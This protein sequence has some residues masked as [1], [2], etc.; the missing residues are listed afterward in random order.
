MPGYVLTANTDTSGVIKVKDISTNESPVQA[1][2]S[3]AND[4]RLKV[5]E[6][7]SLT[8]LLSDRLFGI[9]GGV[10]QLD[11]DGNLSMPGYVLTANT[12]TSGVIKVKD[13]STNESPV[14][15]VR[16]GAND[17]R[18]KVLEQG[19]LTSLLSDR[20]FGISGGVP[21]LNT[22]G[23]I[24]TAHLPFLIEEY[25]NHTGT[26][27][28][29]TIKNT[30]GTG[31]VTEDS[32]THSIKIS[33]GDTYDSRGGIELGDSVPVDKNVTVLQCKVRDYTTIPNSLSKVNIG[34]SS[35][36]NH[37]PFTVNIG[38]IYTNDGTWEVF[39]RDKVA[40]ETTVQV[41]ISKGDILTVEIYNNSAVLFINGGQVY[42]APSN[43]LEGNMTPC[44]MAYNHFSPPAAAVNMYVDAISLKR[45][46]GR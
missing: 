35:S 4:W 6:Q 2:R 36:P 23:R 21:Q 18:L 16:S 24:E 29:F 19:S 28:N 30:Q 31:S 7:G 42:A 9:S 45:Y 20:L 10:P 1:V 33:S 34:F 8:S 14:Q 43:I 3:G 5:L 25:T 37:D 13:I 15:A 44:I 41:S 26:L 32:L 39:L 27:D 22:L 11:P 12:D 40:N 38:F 46:K 17:W